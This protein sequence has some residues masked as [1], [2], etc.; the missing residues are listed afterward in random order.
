MTKVIMVHET[1][2]PEVLKVEDAE[3]GDPGPGEARVRH[4]A[5][6]LNFIDTYFRSGLYPAPNGLPFIPGNEGA[7]VVTAVGDDVADVS[8]GDRVAYVGPI[9]AYAEERL[10]PAASLVRLPEAIDMRTAA[11]MMLKGL[12]AQ[13]L[14][15]QTYPVKAGQTILFHAAAG[16][17]GLIACQWANALGATVI[18]TV[19]SEDKAELARAHG[20]H[21]V[22]NYRTENFVDRVAEITGGNKCDV[23]YDSVGKDTFPGSLDCLKPHAMWVPFGQSSGPITDFNLGMLAQKGSLYVCRPILFT[24]ITERSNLVAMADE[25]MARIADG[26][27]RIEINQEFPLLEAADAHRALEGRKTTGATVLVP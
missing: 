4:E 8:V 23:V 24:Y 13:A 11:A 18:G 22:I 20:C 12:T 17:V 9:G 27:I 7:G 1:G 26:T 21:H 6:G 19:G 3:I 5:V 16:G 25:M 2:G 10:V 14:L 15:R